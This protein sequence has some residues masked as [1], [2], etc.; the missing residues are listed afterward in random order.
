M[1]RFLLQLLAIWKQ[2]LKLYVLAAWIGAGI[3]IFLLAPSYDYISSRERNADPLSSI[4]FVFMQF[5]E[6][7]TGQI[8]Q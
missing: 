6:V 1:K 2:Q 3:G 7:M 5:K 4:E 8:N